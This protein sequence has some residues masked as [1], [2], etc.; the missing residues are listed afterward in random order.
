MPKVS[1]KGD[2]SLLVEAAPMAL[3]REDEAPGSSNLA[4][5]KPQFPPLNAFEQS[6]KKVEFRRVRQLKTHAT[7]IECVD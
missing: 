1:K 7:I 2:A 6:G 4:P 3:D 5:L